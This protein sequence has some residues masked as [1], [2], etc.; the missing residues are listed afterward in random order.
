MA[1]QT[2]LSELL[3]FSLGISIIKIVFV[4]K[5]C[6]C[7]TLFVS[8]YFI[9]LVCYLFYLIFAFSIF[10]STRDQD[11]AT[12][13]EDVLFDMFKNEETDLL[14]VGKF[15]AVCTTRIDRL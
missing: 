7:S 3:P 5:R 15:L 6:W 8:L 9:C 4:S 12:N 11:Q 13:A 1:L 2:H 10:Y 14:S